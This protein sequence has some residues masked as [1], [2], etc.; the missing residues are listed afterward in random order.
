MYQQTEQNTQ[1]KLQQPHNNQEKPAGHTASLY[2]AK[3]P[4]TG[5]DE[6]TPVTTIHQKPIT[7]LKLIITL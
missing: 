7:A 1:L 6:I 5:S 4:V 2:M 3:K